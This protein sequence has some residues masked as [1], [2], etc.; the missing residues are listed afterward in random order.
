M[1]RFFIFC[2]LLCTNGVVLGQHGL[3]DNDGLDGRKTVQAEL[4]IQAISSQWGV[5]ANIV[6]P[7]ELKGTQYLFESW[8]QEAIFK[9]LNGSEFKA[10]SVNFNTKDNQFQSKVT[11]SEMFTFTSD[12]FESVEVDN[13]LF[14]RKYSTEH[15]GYRFYEL[16]IQSE[17]FSI[18]KDFE[19]IYDPG[20][21]RSG[22]TEAVIVQTLKT[23]YYYQSE[24]VKKKFIPNLRGVKKI[25]SDRSDDIKKYVKSLKLNTRNDDDL[26]RIA[27]YYIQIQL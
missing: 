8:D 1:C 14:V 23:T 5:A 10:N 21:V 16:L 9:S 11:S 27:L 6:G 15:N 24:G 19:I 2:L 25:F 7:L 3:D 22:V 4:A 13:R 26:K 17:H 12:K 20:K 18:Y